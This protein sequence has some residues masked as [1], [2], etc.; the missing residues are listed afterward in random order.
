MILAVGATSPF[1]E[2]LAITV[3]VAALTS[4]A[5]RRFGLPSVLGYLLAGLLVGPYLPLPLFADPARTAALSE[6]GVVLV[7][8]G[9]GLHFSPRDL[10]EAIGKAG[11]VGIVQVS[12]M[13][14]FG[15]L[16]GRAFGWGVLPSVF[17]GSAVAISSTMVVAKAIDEYG[18]PTATREL[19][20]G[21]LVLQ[22]LVAVVLIAALT[23]VAS[24]AGLEP[25]ELALTTGGLL[26]FLAVLVIVGQIVVPRALR[27]VGAMQHAE[28]LIIAA[29]G[30]CFA[31]ALLA[32]KAGYSVALGAFVAGS[33]TASSGLAPRIEPLVSP[34]RDL[35][36]AVFFVSVGMMVDP[37]LVLDIWPLA[38]AVAA[39][40]IIGQLVVVSTAAF[41][42]GQGLRRGIQAG[43]TL[44]QVGEFSFILTQ[45][46]YTSGVADGSIVSIAVVAAIITA[47]TTP[48][49]VRHSDRIAAWIDRKLPHRFHTVAAL[50]QSWIAALVTARKQ[51]RIVGIRR[52]VRLAIIDAIALVGLVALTR[53]ARG[54]VIRAGDRIGLG[55]DTA[56]IG[57]GVVV[58]VISVPFV[59]GLV[60]CGRA[61]GTTLA[62]AALPQ[63]TSGTDL[64]FAPRRVLVVVIQ[65]AT[66]MVIG[67]PVLAITGPMLPTWIGAP[68]LTGFLGF[69]AV[70]FWQRANDLD[71][72]V[73]A[74]AQ[75]V[76]ELLR[77]TAG[78]PESFDAEH[79][80][81][82]LPGLGEI[83]SVRLPAAA[84]VC[85][86]TLAQIDLRGATGATVI[87]IDRAGESRAVP[88][89][90]EPLQPDD[91]LALVGTPDAITRARAVLLGDA[92]VAG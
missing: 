10:T 34:I 59:V 83:A 85:G 23:T 60:R 65:L 54:W 78:E 27:M 6:F 92:P 87:A 20:F 76:A 51:R 70:S 14:W 47:T 24:G 12:A 49:A 86:K 61:I 33:L 36:A 7:M 62:R 68:V 21:V 46:A 19:V 28:T 18:L 1:V 35:F 74:G 13:L 11:L 81:R 31:V 73:R 55:E 50:Y 79:I 77:R 41:V 30:L 75:A 42:A 52:F 58:A 26:G 57:L 8:F 17:L 40:V 39:L 71:G 53:F 82:V 66:L 29:V 89:G 2:D 25:R 72:H 69:V 9:I 56:V 90:R 64:A 15:F 63:Q 91:V 88:S 38:L 84:P 16:L 45:L 80:E 32:A 43:L 5:C 22:D 67:L 37:V 4:V 44:G 48:L 3:G